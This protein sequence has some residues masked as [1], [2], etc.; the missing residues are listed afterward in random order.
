[1]CSSPHAGDKGTAEDNL[2]F[3]LGFLDRFPALRNNSLWLSGES[4]AGAV[5][6]AP[7]SSTAA[8]RCK[9]LATLLLSQ[10]DAN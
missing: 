9:G 6:G 5:V 3:L 8:Y 2:A 10:T 1:M 4:Y 7:A